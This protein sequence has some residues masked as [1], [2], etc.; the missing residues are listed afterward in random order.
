MDGGKRTARPRENEDRIYLYS[1]YIL[2]ILYY[3]TIVGG[4]KLKGN[5]M[6]SGEL[7][8]FE[9]LQCDNA[10]ALARYS[11]KR[12]CDSESI[13][14]ESGVVKPTTGGEYASPVLY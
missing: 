4:L 12:F 6:G 8:Q 1:V 2:Y 9:A 3:S 5:K 10:H 7:S 14:Q 11:S 13:K